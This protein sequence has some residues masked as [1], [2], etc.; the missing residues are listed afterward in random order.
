[1]DTFANSFRMVSINILLWQISHDLYFLC[2]DSVNSNVWFLK[3]LYELVG[4]YR[5][6]SYVVIILSNVFEL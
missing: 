3:K 1:M 4:I 6:V 5:L 2:A